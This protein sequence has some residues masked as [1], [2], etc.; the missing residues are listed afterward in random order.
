MLYVFATRRSVVITLLTHIYAVTM[1][2]DIQIST[3]ADLNIEK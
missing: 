3:D 1:H 2:S